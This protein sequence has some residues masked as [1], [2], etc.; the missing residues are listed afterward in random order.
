MQLPMR[1]RWEHDKAGA[2]S[3]YNPLEAAKRLEAAGI[4]RPH[5]EAIATEIWASKTAMTET[6]PSPNPL[7]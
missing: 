7:P 1:R 6:V 2:M 3:R 4:P 5:A